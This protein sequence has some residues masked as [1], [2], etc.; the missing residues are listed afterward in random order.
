MKQLTLTVILKDKKILLGMKKRG[1]GAGLWNG[2][3]GKP[4]ENEPLLDCVLRETFE[5]SNITLTELELVG[6]L[7]FSFTHKPDWNQQVH[8]FKTSNF[9]GTPIETEEMKPKYFKIED[10]PYDKMWSDDKYWLPKVLNN[11]KVRAQI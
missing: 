2:F 4:N 5:E 10:I 3:G 9:K 1:F 11:K 7:D 8:I 6:I